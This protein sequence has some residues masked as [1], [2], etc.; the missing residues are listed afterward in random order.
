MTFDRT[1]TQGRV[2]CDQMEGNSCLSM[3]ENQEMASRPGHSSHQ[4]NDGEIL[5]SSNIL[6][7]DLDCTMHLFCYT[8]VSV[9]NLVLNHVS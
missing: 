9:T 6:K 3:E 4:E 7:K 8:P 1:R 2:T 5:R